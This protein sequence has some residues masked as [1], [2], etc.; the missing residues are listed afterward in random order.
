[1]TVTEQTP[2]LTEG[3]KKPWFR[4]E[5]R[6]ATF[7]E[8]LSG[9]MLTIAGL[10][11]LLVLVDPKLNIPLTEG[12]ILNIGGTGFS[13][14]LKGMVIG[15]ILVGGFNSIRE[16]WLGATAG[17]QKASSVVERMAEGAAPA[18]AK[19]AEKAIDTIAALP[20][21]PTVSEP[22]PPSVDGIIPAPK[23]TQ[24][25]PSKSDTPT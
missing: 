14:D 5:R 16:Y 11:A 17:G 19:V 24:T 12:V 18:A 9:R 1:M 10:G 13:N 15:A 7:Q 2:D 4:R 22:A 25:D 23:A 8:T 21:L 6:A 20:P 3:G